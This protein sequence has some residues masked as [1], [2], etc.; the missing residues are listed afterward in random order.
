MT[1]PL[2]PATD[3]KDPD[4]LLERFLDYTA[5]KGIEL[6]PAQ[7][8]AI[9][10]IFAGKHVILNTPTGSGKSLVAAAMHFYSASLGRRSVYTCPIKA[11]VNEK[12][13]ALCRDFGPENVG[14]M[15]GDA[16]VN[17]NA[18][19]LCCTAEILSN[20]AL[21]D[22]EKAKVHDVIMDEFH[23]YSDHERGVAWQVPLLTLPQSKF[24]LI[25]ATLGET[26]FF[27]R[28]L[29]DLTGVE[30]VT[31]SSKQRPVPL[32][33]S[34]LEIPMVEA[35]DKLREQ[36][37]LPCYIVHFTQ[38][39]ASDTAQNLLSYNACSKEEKELIKEELKGVEFTSPFGKEIKKCL[40]NGI[41]LHHAGLLPKYRV[42][43][44]K[45]AQKGLLKFICGTDTLGVGVNVPIRTVLFTQLCK[46]GGR[47]TSILSARDFHQ[48]SGRAGRKGYDDHG[49]VVAL[50][51]E[52]V[53]ENKRAEARA[54]NDAKK[55]KKLVKKKPPAKGFVQW[56]EE[57]Y[58]K[59]QKAPA[60]PL[61]SR[62]AV[63]HGML[64]NVLS[65]EGDGCRAMRKLINDSHNLPGTKPAL[66]KKAFQLFRALVERE[67]IEI[68]PPGSNGQK[69][70]LNVELQDDFSLNQTL[71]LYCVD[72]LA[73]LDPK[74][75]EYALKLLSLAESILENPDVIL[76]KQLDKLKTEKMAEMKADGIEY[77]ERIEKLE[78]MEYPKP[79]ADFIYETF[80]EFA[81]KHPWVGSENIKPKSIAREMFERYSSFSD[82]IKLYGLQ[83]AEGLVLRH[84]TNVY[85]VLENTIPE[86]FRDDQV[87]EMIIYFE[88]LLRHVDSSLIDE[89]ELMRNPEY[90]A[91]TLDADSL[92]DTERASDITRDRSAFTRLIRNELFSFI[93]LLA[94]GQYK[95]LEDSY[96][97]APLFSETHDETPKWMDVELENRMASYYESRSWIRLDPAARN[98]EHTHIT[99]SDDRQSWTVEQMLIDPEELNDWALTAEVDVP[100]S[101]AAEKVIFK[102]VSLKPIS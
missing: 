65:R 30:C 17:R 52:H 70:T 87:D 96:D 64:L 82:Y 12:F 44:E 55:K 57:T 67:I 59:L 9:L 13:L 99:I 88:H 27:S 39:A 11:L 14:M 19:I 90:Q 38:R 36:N 101:K 53:I 68:A 29:E 20:I 4:A 97:L 75:P 26:A 37:K 78:S 85:R 62:F 46:Y 15:T 58:D 18:P 79:E 51:P 102:L 92:P 73:L 81:R 45:F 72:T 6:Y 74:D 91:S 40:L 69:L 48:I 41:G 3:T 31:V 23:Y 16:S 50:A 60:E 93:S 63:S 89:W 28:G 98:K 83:R 8:E 95:E 94:A 32:E 71:S 22:G 61:E 76:R 100:A 84:I 7:E 5:E 42:L 33:F 56:D 35:L 1:F 43:V 77:D 2:E 34:Y 47:K 49:Y 66:R 21:R 86:G 54:G 80:N 24:L 25:S 10:E